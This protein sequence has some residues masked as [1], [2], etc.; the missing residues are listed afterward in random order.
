VFAA[1]HESG[2]GPSR[3]FQRLAI[4]VAIGEE[5]TWLDLP[6]VPPGRGFA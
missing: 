1:V 2:C 5:R 6:L 3:R 4:S